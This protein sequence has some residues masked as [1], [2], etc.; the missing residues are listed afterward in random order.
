MLNTCK[1]ILNWFVSISIASLIIATACIAWWQEM[2]M[3]ETS[4][5]CTE[6]VLYILQTRTKSLK[7]SNVSGVWWSV[8]LVLQTETEKLHFCV[9]PWSLL[10]ILLTFTMLLT[11][12]NGGRQTQQCFNVSAPSSRRGNNSIWKLQFRYVGLLVEVSIFSSIVCYYCF[13]YFFS[14]YKHCFSLG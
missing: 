4:V 1:N 5:F 8:K 13:Y 10:A 14:F 3:L 9:R 6:T 11:F 7:P 12:P 2:E